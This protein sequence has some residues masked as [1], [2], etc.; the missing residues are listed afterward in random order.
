VRGIHQCMVAEVRF[1]PG[2]TDPIGNG[3]TPSSSNRLSQRN[4]AIVESDNPGTIATH[5][6]Q[7]TLLMK[8]SRLIPNQI[9]A[10]ASSATAPIE[11]GG[12]YDELVIRWND[13]PRDTLANI[14]CPDWQADEI[15][16]AASTL[17]TGPQR[18][19]K[20]DANTIACAVGDITFIPIPARRQ[21]MPALLTLK[22]PLDVRDGQQFR[23]DVQQHSGPTFQGSNRRQVEGSAASLK[24]FNFSA[25]KVLG[26][27]RVTVAVKIGEPLLAKL[28]RNLAVLRYI[29][30]AIPPADSWHPVF[31]RYIGQLS[32]QIKGLGVDPDS[33]PASADDPGIPGRPDGKRE[34][35]MGKVSEVIFDCFG[36]FEGFVLETCDECHRHHFR[37]RERGIKKL[38]LRAC[39]ESLLISVCVSKECDGKIGE[40]I[41]RPG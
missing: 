3:A 36:D 17:R 26:A 28:V 13:L 6:V 31:V 29:F 37:T 34:C 33:V 40:I 4:L 10:A 21:P 39:K 8:P 9:F 16:A 38:V 25:R 41:V 15:L 18:L 12:K 24:S 20:V 27:F 23:V 5:T 14:Y 30:E 35:F 22:L 19:S 2:A 7:H 11:T 1:Q 32:D